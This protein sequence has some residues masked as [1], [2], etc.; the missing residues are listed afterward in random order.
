MYCMEGTVF[1]GTMPRHLTQADP[2]GGPASSLEP[3]VTVTIQPM[4][5]N[6]SSVEL[7]IPF[8]PCTKGEDLVFLVSNRAEMKAI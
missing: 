8:L 3:S 5:H 4:I 2:R 7:M 6:R 1:Q